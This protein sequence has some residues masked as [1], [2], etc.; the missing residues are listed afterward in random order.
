MNNKI[1]IAVVDDDPIIHDTLHEFYQGSALAEIKY[2]FTNP[3]KF[4]D[5]APGLDFDLCLLDIRM[6]V[7]NGLVVAQMLNSKPVIFLT[8]SDDMLKDALQLSPIDVITKPFVKVRLDCALEKAAKLIAE[9]IEYAVFSVAESSKKVKIYLPDIV[10]VSVDDID[11]RNKIVILKGGTKYTLMDYSLDE[12][13][14]LAQ[15]LIQ[16][17]R[18]T[19]VSLNCI[20]EMSYDKVTLHDADDSG[21]PPEATLTRTHKEELSRRMF[22]K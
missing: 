22:Y 19:L 13:K 6:P 10:F 18:H 17:N 4:M 21:L 12:I 15:Q 8:G 14:S 11:A 9:N 5:A 1:K 2:D 16:I 3:Q 20:H 7:M